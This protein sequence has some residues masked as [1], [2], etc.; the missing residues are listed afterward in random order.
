MTGGCGLEA[1]LGD[2]V[3][4]GQFV[5][6]VPEPDTPNTL[7]VRVSDQPGGSVVLGDTT[8]SADDQGWAEL[9]LPHDVNLR[10]AIV[11]SPPLSALV[12]P[13]ATAVALDDRTTA[14]VRFLTALG[15]DLQSADG[16]PLLDLLNSARTSGGHYYRQVTRE[17]LGLDNTADQ[18]LAALVAGKAITPCV[19]DARIRVVFQV[20]MS[21]G[22]RDGNC[23]PID[24]F[25]WAA[26]VPD[27]AMFIT[28]GVHEE[29]VGAD[30]ADARAAHAALGGWLPNV[31]PMQDSGDGLWSFVVDLPRSSPPLQLGYKFTWGLKGAT[32]TATEEWPGNQR[33]LEVVDVDGDG[34]VV[35]RDSFGDEASN[36]DRQNLR[37][38]GLGAIDYGDPAAREHAVDVDGDCVADEFPRAANVSPPL[39]DCQDPAP[40]PAVSVGTGPT[41]VTSAEPSMGGNGGGEVV[42]IAGS[43]FLGRQHVTFGGQP[44]GAVIVR[45]PTE[46]VAVSPR[47][48]EGPA[49]VAVDGRQGPALTVVGPGPGTVPA[50]ALSDSGGLPSVVG[51]LHEGAEFWVAASVGDPG[52]AVLFAEHMVGPA[53][54]D[55]ALEPGWSVTPAR[56]D[57]AGG[58][59]GAW[60]SLPGPGVWSHG[61]RVTADAG[62]T[63]RYCDDFGTFEVR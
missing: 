42:T 33:L 24:P 14:D 53:A 60:M 49:A 57:P 11:R 22:M 47:L 6:Y 34:L 51:G 59:Y 21:G 12:P 61:F 62:R 54:T 29:F 38:G 23:A 63:W 35:V 55:P 36:K 5:Q 4:G 41:T 31:V 43:G 19:D 44:S 18:A 32:W 30:P 17:L 40:P 45:S 56:R 9:Q 25:R 26:D 8:A 15:G 50:C 37:A 10:F 27:A 39:G 1:T 2:A 16:L 28:G 20:R 52:G 46:L 58:Q 7:R 13:G 3:S 48:L